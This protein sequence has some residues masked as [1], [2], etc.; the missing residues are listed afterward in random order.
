MRNGKIGSIIEG[1]RVESRESLDNT[2]KVDESVRLSREEVKHLERFIEVAAMERFSA[3]ITN[4]I[5]KVI[6]KDFI[7]LTRLVK[8]IKKG[9]DDYGVLEEGA[10][11]DV[12]ETDE[13]KKIED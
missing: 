11:S 13:S 9:L 10:G 12:E 7:D 5:T 6:I 1:L 3:P 2:S 4:N 8:E